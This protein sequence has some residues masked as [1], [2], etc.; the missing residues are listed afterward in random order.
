[1]VLVTVARHSSGAA[2]GGEKGL[3]A[4]PAAKNALLG[5]AQGDGHGVRHQILVDPKSKSLHRA[6]C[7]PL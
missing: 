2:G 5:D 3:A 6:V 4:W 1:M 7:S